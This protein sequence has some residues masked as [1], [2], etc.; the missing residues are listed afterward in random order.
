MH[1]CYFLGLVFLWTPLTWLHADFSE[2]LNFMYRTLLEN[3]PGPT[4]ESDPLFQGQL[5]Y[6]YKIAKKSWQNHHD[7]DFAILEDFCLYFNDRNLSIIHSASKQDQNQPSLEVFQITS[8]KPAVLQIDIPT[9][10]L[11]HNS[12]KESFEQMIAE[13]E[14]IDFHKTT[15]IFNLQGNQGGDCEQ[16]IRVLNAI[17]PAQ[18]VKS[19]ILQAHQE[20]CIDW[21]AST[22]NTNYMLDRADNFPDHLKIAQGM[23]ISKDAG[24]PYYREYMP[25]FESTEISHENP[26]H[27]EKII[28]IIDRNNI[29]AA[30]DFIDE[31]KFL[32]LPLILIGEKTGSDRL[33][34]EVR[35]V[36][37]PSSSAILHFP[38]K[39]YRNR[40]RADRQPYLPDYSL[41]L[42]SIQDMDNLLNQILESH[43]Q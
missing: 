35:T 39:V 23:R 1:Y 18:W 5:E 8:P 17:F 26:V 19:K 4:N 25:L 10:N 27:I 2:D 12:T 43:P 6:A 16:G 34:N 11:S 36:D 31:L 29:G 40:L 22:D 38:I 9:F 20:V 37:L 30:L 15:I 7:D 24:L 21:R 33:Y 42:T 41:N 14:K 28:V 3:H 13:I 32:D